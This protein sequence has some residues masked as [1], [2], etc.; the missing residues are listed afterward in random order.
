MEAASAFGAKLDYPALALRTRAR[1]H[2]RAGCHTP[3]CRKRAAAGKRF[4]GSCQATLDRV[5]EELANAGPRG[6]KPSIRRAA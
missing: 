1:S 3:G 6:R 2:R 5:R 4:C